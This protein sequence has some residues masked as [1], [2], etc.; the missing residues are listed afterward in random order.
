MA[1]RQDQGLQIAL[2]VF[3]FLFV[4]FAAMSY[5]FFKSSSDAKQHVAELETQMRDS[6]TK[7]SKQRRQ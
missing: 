7:A 6:D 3:V 2:I 5:L 4:V 1:A